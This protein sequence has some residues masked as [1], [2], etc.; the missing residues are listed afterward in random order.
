MKLTSNN[1]LFSN[2][3][4][5]Y[6]NESTSKNNLSINNVFNITTK[7]NCIEPV[8]NF[9]NLLNYH[10]DTGFINWLKT[11][12]TDIINN[13]IQFYTY[14][15][16]DEESNIIKSRYFIINNS[17]SLFEIDKNN[18]ILID[19]NLKFSTKPKFIL[20]DERLYLYSFNDLFLM[21]HK[22]NYPIPLTDV[23]NVKSIINFDNFTIF[24]TLEN[25]FSIFYT[26]LTNLSNLEFNTIN[27]N[28]I[29]LLTEN[30]EIENLFI[31]KNN[32]Y[33]VQKY[34]ISKIII[35]DKKYSIQNLC[36][37]KSSIIIDSIELIDDYVI[38]LTNAGLY[39]FDG[40]DTKQ[41]FKN[42]TNNLIKD[43]VKSVS[44][45]NKYYLLCNYY[46]NNIKN[47]L[48][49]EF[50]IENENCTFY[51]IE[52]A[53]DIYILQTIKTYQLI[54][55]TES[56]N[57]NEL[58]YLDFNTL[59]TLKK[60][61]KFNKLTFDETPVKVLNEI[62]IISAGKYNLTISSEI[63]SSIF[64]INGVSYIRNI[65]IKGQAF[66]IE[67]ESNSTFKIESIYLKTTSYTED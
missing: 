54:I 66:Q 36:S 60:Y 55:V 39:I 3:K 28:E 29:K 67:I 14:D 64:E 22:N 5:D 59:T 50:D 16:F 57:F 65:G 18:N 21:I 49:L 2:F 23:I 30:G 63:Q 45:N 32:I 61:I 7:N 40:N 62:K 10:F 43:N 38:F 19:L 27:Y 11:N 58:K 9:S 51:K 52:N 46:V 4:L 31:Y 24:T 48:I 34:A 20:I 1:Y 15:Y 53:T 26:D 47:K 41:I 12:H 25:M 44:F 13:I 37:V 17:Y 6:L 33:V 42:I 8:Y 56:E 35:Q